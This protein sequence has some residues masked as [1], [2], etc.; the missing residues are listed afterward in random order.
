VLLSV[1]AQRDVGMS[2]PVDGM[3]VPVAL[4]DATGVLIVTGS[5][6]DIPGFTADHLRLMQ[7]LAA[8]AAVA[9]TNVRL[10]DRLRHI[11]LHD[12]LTDLPN[13]RQFLT[14]VQRATDAMAITPYTVGVLLLDLDQFNDVNDALGHDVGDDLLREIGRRLQVEFGGRGA[15]ARLGG[16]EFA[17]VIA[18][19]ESTEEVLAIATELRRAIERPIPVGNLTLTTQASIGVSFAPDHGSDARRLLQRADVAM[20]AAKHARTGVRIYRP[21]DDPN[22]PR[23]FALL[24]DLRVAIDERALEVVYQPK[25]DPR[26]GAVVGAEALCRWHHVDGPVP[27]DEFIPL[28]EHS[29]L[30]RPLT[31]HVLDTALASCAAWRRAGHDISVA[32]NLSPHTLADETLTDEVQRALQRHG[33]PAAALTLEI[34]ENSI[35]DDP[36]HIHIT[37]TSLYAL[38]VKLSI[39]DFGTGHSSLGRLAEMPIHEMK[40]DK[41]FVRD[42]MVKPSRR[43]VTDASLQ[44]GR[45][46]DLIVVAEGVEDRAEFEYLREQGCDT[47]Q[48]Y[49][50]SK[51][52]GAAEF[53]TWLIEHSGATPTTS[54][55]APAAIRPVSSVR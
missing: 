13:R 47:I 22:T 45:A 52:L 17:V 39:D 32:V 16:D 19:A 11:A 15:V 5:L 6:P 31:R 21:E 2:Y 50:I 20:Y 4:D 18:R 9:L 46:L 7:A 3:A 51:P 33:V 40:I 27:P 12:A 1:S 8:H 34:T 38:G 35:M 28:A 25:V 42:L 54:A 41:S 36:T 23:R 44:L 10:V 53:M 29:G 48:G 30:I 14:E 55:S 37:L 43:A 49:Y 26:S 24:A